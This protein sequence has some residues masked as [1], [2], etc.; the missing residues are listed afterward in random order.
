MPDVDRLV[1]E[2]VGLRRLVG[3]CLRGRRRFLHVMG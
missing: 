3:R 2:V 1:D